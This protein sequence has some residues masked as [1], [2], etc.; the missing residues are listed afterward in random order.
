MNNIRYK[1]H[2]AFLLKKMASD[3]KSTPRRCFEQIENADPQLPRGSDIVAGVT[4]VGLGF[5]PN[6]V[7]TKVR[8]V[9]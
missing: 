9:T 3:R 7:L 5:S 4:V 8:I 6:N 1:H 2:V